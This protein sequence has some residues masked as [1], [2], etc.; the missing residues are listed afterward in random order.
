MSAPRPLRFAPRPSLRVGVAAFACLGL[1]AA[2]CIRDYEDPNAPSLT[3]GDEETPADGPPPENAFR[4]RFET[5]KGDFVVQVRPD[6]APLGAARFKTLVE[7][8]YFDEAAFFRV[9]PGFVAQFGLAADPAVTAKWKNANLKDDPVLVSNTPGRLTFAT[10][11]PNSRTTQIFINYGNNSGSLDPKGFSPFAEIVSGDEVPTKFFSGYGEGPP[12]GTG[13]DQGKLTTQGAAYLE[14]QFPK[15]DT[16]K[17][18]R[19]IPREEWA[20][21]PTAAD[22]SSADGES[23]GST[24]DEGAEAEPAETAE[25]ET[26]DKPAETPAPDEPAEVPA[27]E[28]PA[29]EE[30]AGDEPAGNEPAS[31][32]S[33]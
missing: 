24:D 29:A 9:L 28:E 13:V 23:G 32:S 4:V 16:I 22:G 3:G 17:T 8:K 11:G 5:T 33:R 10:S 14:K 7:E 30:P 27:P 12:Q 19:I 26:T 25:P 15:L 1:L 21:A 20:E 6:W 18:A 2:G 31:G